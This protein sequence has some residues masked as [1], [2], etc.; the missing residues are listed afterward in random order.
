MSNFK[1]VES[2]PMCDGTAGQFWSFINV[3]VPQLVLNCTIIVHIHA[4]YICNISIF[5]L[6]EYENCKM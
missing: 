1:I 2:I 3:I 5:N 6:E 4:I